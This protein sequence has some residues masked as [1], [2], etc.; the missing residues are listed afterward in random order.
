MRPPQ[1]VGIGEERP[2]VGLLAR[3]QAGA[4][5]A[6]GREPQAVAALAEVLRDAGDEADRPGRAGSRQ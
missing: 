2:H 4:Q 6:V 5:A 3:E 1:R